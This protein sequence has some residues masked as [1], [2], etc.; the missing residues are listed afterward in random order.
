MS[1]W[2]F[3]AAS[4]IW[5]KKTG[6]PGTLRIGFVTMSLAGTL[7]VGLGWDPVINSFFNDWWEYDPSTNSWHQKSNV[8]FEE[9]SLNFCWSIS[10]RGYLAFGY[11][12]FGRTFDDFW[13]YDPAKD[14]WIEKNAKGLRGSIFRGKEEYVLTIGNKPT[15]LLGTKPEILK[16]FQYDF[17]AG[18]WKVEYEWANKFNGGMTTFSIGSSHYFLFGQSTEYL[19]E[20]S[21]AGSGSSN[22]VWVFN[23]H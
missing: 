6:F 8:P 18:E 5:T 9:R 20:Q 2:A 13:E 14:S 11:G 7:Y 16:V 22:K 4:D 15:I 19:F 1:V 17:D 12:E 3:E 23:E 10:N 21:S